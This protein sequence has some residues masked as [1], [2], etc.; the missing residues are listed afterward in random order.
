MQLDLSKFQLSASSRKNEDIEWSINY[1]FNRNDPDS[2]RFLIVGDSICNGYQQVLREKL[3]A[4]A[5]LSFWASSYCVTD[6]M[7]LP[8]LDQV[9]NGPRP[10]LIIFNNGL[11]SLKSDR[12][13]WE[14]AFTLVLK[15]IM[16]KFPGIPLAVLNSTPLADRDTRVDE[17]NEMTARAAERLHLPL[18]DIF[19]LCKEFDP[20]CWRDNYHFSPEAIGMQAEFL[21]GKILPL[22]PVKGNKVTIQAS[23]ETGPDGA[24]K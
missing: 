19:S 21:A 2:P 20:S 13:E 17:I 5:S 4:N 24:L 15:F 9:C 23:T 7:Y 3:S 18:W 14:E 6:L 1:V 8:A 10:D 16:A 22:L 12:K 11:H